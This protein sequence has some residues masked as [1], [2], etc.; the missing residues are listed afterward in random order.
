MIEKL[1]AYLTTR[2]PWV[3]LVSI[4]IMISIVAVADYLTG[5]LL[6][7]SIFYIAPVSLASWYARRS[8]IVATCLVSTAAW[9]AAEIVSIDYPNGWIPVWNAAV[10]L[11]FFA[12]TSVLLVALKSLIQRQIE[13]ADH[14]NLTGLFN[15]RAFEDRC[16]YLFQLA[17]RQ[18]LSIALGY[19]DIDRFKTA[20]DEFGHTAG[21]RILAGVARILRQSLRESD[22]T[23][24]M[25]G[26]EFVFA[27]PDTGFTEARSQTKRMVARLRQCASAEGWPIGFSLGVVVC[28]PPLPDFPDALSFADELMYAV[29]KQPDDGF[30]IEEFLPASTTNERNGDGTIRPTERAKQVRGNRAPECQ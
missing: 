25:G 30:R 14:D 10:R 7:F 11:G 28:R 4:G 3:L 15:R 23:G 22:I 29:K 2:S 6:S 12:I 26:D 27:L 16:Q 24:R 19:L 20:N 9:L 18:D 17:N 1:H 5:P 21:D 8:I 13:L